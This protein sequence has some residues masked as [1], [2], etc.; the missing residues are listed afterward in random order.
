MRTSSSF[1]LSHCSPSLLRHSLLLSMDLAD[2]ARLESKPRDA[3]SVS[4]SLE[5][6]LQAHAPMQSAFGVDSGDQTQMLTIAWQGLN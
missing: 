5:Q 1:S 6:G 2:S 3:P 4:A